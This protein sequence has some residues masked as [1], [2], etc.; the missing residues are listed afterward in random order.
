M[1]VNNTLRRIGDSSK[2]KFEKGNLVRIRER[3]ATKYQ[4]C[5][6]TVRDVLTDSG[7]APIY[8]VFLTD[9]GATVDVLE[10]ALEAIEKK[11]EPKF[12]EGDS[13][14]VRA[15][16]K[17]LHR[18]CLGVVEALGLWPDRPWSY[19]IKIDS[20]GISERMVFIESDLE[21]AESGKEGSSTK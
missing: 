9:S 2:P 14:R 16:A 12:K 11:T 21:P 7:G 18:G 17:I 10:D 1:L 5:P 15:D 19:S 13:V 20:K 6:G 3:A 8:K 4:G